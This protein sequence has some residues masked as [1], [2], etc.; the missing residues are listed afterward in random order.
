MRRSMFVTVALVAGLGVL[1]LSGAVRAAIVI[2]DV[3]STS[4]RNASFDGSCYIGGEDHGYGDVIGNANLFGISGAEIDKP[5]A[6][7]FTVKINTAYAGR[8]G[9]YDTHYG[10]LFLDQV[11]RAGA[12]GVP[13]LPSK[14]GFY[15]EDNN[16]LNDVFLTG[17]WGYVFVMDDSSPGA[18]SSGT[19]TGNGSLYAVQEENIVFADDADLNGTWRRSDSTSTVSQ[20]VQ[21]AVNGVA[22]EDI[23]FSGGVLGDVALA[24]GTWLV[25]ADNAFILF[26]INRAGIPGAEEVLDFGISWG[27]TCANDIVQGWGQLPPVPVPGAFLL[28]ATA[29]SGL[30]FMGWMRRRAA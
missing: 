16:Y 21:Y 24:S 28:L 6:N 22:D 29:L 23:N 1:A 27:M 25:D 14:T 4:D 3:C 5:T 19:Q 17:D 13:P 12:T 26:T 20:P 2:N 7:T 10:S 30:G 9:L 11:W 15:T 8:D 18:I